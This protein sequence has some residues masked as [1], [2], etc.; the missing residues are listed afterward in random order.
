M[1]VAH[2]L[3]AYSHRSH[4]KTKH[5]QDILGESARVAKI[6]A[7]KADVCEKGECCSSCAL[8]IGPRTDSNN[9][10]SS[11][12]ELSSERLS[13]LEGESP[14]L[15]SR[16]EDPPDGGRVPDQVQEDLLQAASEVQSDLSRSMLAALMT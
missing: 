1:D 11:P 4:V 5:S 15:K 13:S 14:S 16:A 9:P 7:C 8:P 3:H 12:S 2:E 6:C 10:P